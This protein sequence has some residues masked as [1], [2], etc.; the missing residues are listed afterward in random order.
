MDEECKVIGSLLG[1]KGRCFDARF[2]PDDSKRLVTASEDGNAKVWDITRKSCLQTLNHNK[3]AEVLRASFTNSAVVT[4]GSD[5]VVKIWAS[6]VSE[7][8]SQ[9]QHYSQ[10]SILDHGGED[11]QVYVCE[12]DCDGDI[13]MTGVE[14]HLL[15]WDMQTQKRLQDFSYFDQRDEAF[16]GSSRNPDK[17]S[18]VFDAKWRPSCSNTAVV[19]L[20]DSTLR[21]VDTRARQ[22]DHQSIELDDES[23]NLG[24]ATAV[25]MLLV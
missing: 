24:H 13:L 23:I 16:G 22:E 12:P 3:N 20:S 17:Q 7:T 18:Y 1:H 2:H 19:A 11:S 15:L 14:N 10:L 8:G 21:F 5:G 9:S 25:S 4:A 6:S